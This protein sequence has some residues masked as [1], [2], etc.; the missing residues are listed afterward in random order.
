MSWSIDNYLQSWPK[1]VENSSSLVIRTR[2]LRGWPSQHPTFGDVG[3]RATEI[4]KLQFTF[5]WVKRRG[6]ELLF[7]L[8]SWNETWALHIDLQ[9]VLFYCH[10]WNLSWNCSFVHLKCMCCL[11]TFIWHFSQLICLVSLWHL[12]LGDLGRVTQ[13]EYP[14][15][16]FPLGFWCQ[17]SLVEEILF[18]SPI[19][20][21]GPFS[22][23]RMGTE[24]LCR[25]KRFS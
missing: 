23:T 24:H 8:F 1:E 17:L 22:S 10:M 20:A 25:S 5:I 7:C 4:I 15:K 18:R 11:D 19:L 16:L 2:D 3:L 12:P 14:R 13:D 21:W 9:M 6:E